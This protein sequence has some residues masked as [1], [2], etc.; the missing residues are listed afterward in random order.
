MKLKGSSD[1]SISYGFSKT[2][3]SYLSQ[4]ITKNAYKYGLG[5][6]FRNKNKASRKKIGDKHHNVTN[7]SITIS[8]PA[9]SKGDIK[10]DVISIVISSENQR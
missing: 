4:F 5:W 2:K 3:S 9:N 7:T 10:L 1:L 6:Y 8:L